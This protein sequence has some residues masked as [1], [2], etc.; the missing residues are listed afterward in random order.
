M[1][2]STA[3]TAARTQAAAA[4]SADGKSVRKR[5]ARKKPSEAAYQLRDI[6]WRKLVEAGIPTHEA[7]QI[8]NAI[9]L[10]DLHQTPPTDD[11]KLLMGTY[12]V[13]MSEANLWRLE[14][15]LRRSSRRSRRR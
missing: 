15:M 13:A 6:Y 12:C 14:L 3:H 8:A 9:A 5:S 1:A 4:T 10:Y 2:R 11:Q 7:K